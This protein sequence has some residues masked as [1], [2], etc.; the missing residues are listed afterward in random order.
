MR[1][2][3][4]AVATALLIALPAAAFE[5]NPICSDAAADNAVAMSFYPDSLRSS[6]PNAPVFPQVCVQRAN[7]GGT[8]GGYLVAGYSNAHIGALRVIRMSGTPAV[9]ADA[10]VQ[11]ELAGSTPGLELM[12]F[13]GDGTP[14]VLFNLLTRGNSATWL[15]AWTGN[16]LQHIG[17]TKSSG[18]AVLTALRFPSFEDLNGDGL[19][20][21]IQSNATR[22]NPEPAQRET[23]YAIGP[24][25]TVAPVRPVA[26]WGVF[27]RTT[28]NPDA[29]T[30]TVVPAVAGKHVLRIVNGTADGKNAV[31][32]ADVVLNGA[33]VVNPGDF[34]KK[35]R[36]IE[37]PVTLNASNEL[38][39][40]LR[41]AP[42]SQFTLSIS[43]Q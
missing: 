34:K 31:T 18:D 30:L 19:P 1:L 10:P 9:V 5:M 15:Y 6:D 37:V 16:G 12:D 13:N 4:L 28:G 11:P 38:R 21:I 8:S 2:P 7:F 3:A 26:F 35:G 32:A 36:L 24:N 22:W 39:V 27:A 25:G 14:E 20:E 29:F 40:E 17:P 43:Q 33:M 42:G 23:V 41:S